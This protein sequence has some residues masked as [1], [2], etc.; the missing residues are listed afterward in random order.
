MHGHCAELSGLELVIE[1]PPDVTPTCKVKIVV[2]RPICANC[3]TLGWMDGWLEAPRQH[4]TG[5]HNGI[6]SL[7]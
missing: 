3:T 5:E 1:T 6:Y 2:S 4:I 7:M